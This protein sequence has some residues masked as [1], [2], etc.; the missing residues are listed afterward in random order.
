MSLEKVLLP[1]N[2]STWGVHARPIATNLYKFAYDFDNLNDKKEFVVKVLFG[3][4]KDET[5][6]SYFASQPKVRW[7]RKNDVKAKVKI[8]KRDYDPL[9]DDDWFLNKDIL[10][11]QNLKNKQVEYFFYALTNPQK[12]NDNVFEYDAELDV[13]F[14]YSHLNYINPNAY[15]EV[16]QSHFNNWIKNGLEYV[17][18]INYDNQNELFSKEDFDVKPETLVLQKTHDLINLDNISDF[19]LTFDATMQDKK[20]Q[21]AFLYQLNQSFMRVVYFN[22][23]FTQ[24]KAVLDALITWR[25]T[26]GTNPYTLKPFANQNYYILF[27]PQNPVLP[28]GIGQDYYINFQWP[29]PSPDEP[30]QFQKTIYDSVNNL[31]DTNFDKSKEAQITGVI[32]QSMLHNSA[33]DLPIVH[34]LYYM[35]LYKLSATIT[36][37]DT[38]LVGKGGRFTFLLNQDETTYPNQTIMLFQASG[39]PPLTQTPYFA[40]TPMFNL[41]DYI[42]I[43]TIRQFYVSLTI[44]ISDICNN[45]DLDETKTYLPKQEPKMLMHPFTNFKMENYY[46]EYEYFLNN[47]AYQ[48]SLYNNKFS[49]DIRYLI[50]HDFQILNK[51]YY[52][53]LAANFN[54]S[55]LQKLITK[56]SYHNG[57]QNYLPSYNSAYTSWAVDNYNQY[58]TSMNQA[59]IKR[60]EAYANSALGGLSAVGDAL[61]GNFGGAINQANQAVQGGLNA[62]F[63][64]QSLRASLNDRKNGAVGVQPTTS[65][66]FNNLYLHNFQEQFNVYTLN[67]WNFTKLNWWFHK[68]GIKSGMTYQWNRE[69]IQRTMY[70]WDYL[71]MENVYEAIQLYPLGTDAFSNE[72]K[73]IISESLQNGITFFHVRREPASQQLRYVDIKDY[74]HNNVPAEYVFAKW[75]KPSI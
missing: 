69:K 70:W 57:A 12:L 61:E 22:N 73:T 19:P 40:N 51:G 36:K 58:N 14:T 15:V 1:T 47:F 56:M 65:K 72:V 8:D 3:G 34:F 37:E 2:N 10:I 31:L 17:P 21:E 9:Y 26:D 11:L 27:A 44:D 53:F 7:T 41:V 25:T 38:P 54:G 18:N 30:Y 55:Y 60:N 20:D 32:S 4:T 16:V 66:E 33:Y 50:Y 68:F 67:A 52:I 63:G 75:N 45:L 24:Q 64:V 49:F 29:L 59:K 13:F 42:V 48:F 62:N 43:P 6:E 35:T 23:D 46:A 71:Q 39:D 5:L 28:V 74:N